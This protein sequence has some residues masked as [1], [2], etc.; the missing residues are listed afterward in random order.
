MKWDYKVFPEPPYVPFKKGHR[1][2]WNDD[3]LIE[4][5]GCLY[6]LIKPFVTN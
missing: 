3:S 4:E 5:E 2:E 6:F 1:N